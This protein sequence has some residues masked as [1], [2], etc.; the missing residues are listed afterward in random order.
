VYVEAIC[1]AFIAAL[2]A[3]REMIHTQAF[4]VE[5]RGELPHAQIW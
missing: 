5:T 4:K 2:D 1:L 3:A